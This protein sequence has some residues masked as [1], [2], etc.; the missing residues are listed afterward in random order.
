MMSSLIL[1]F[2]IGS[3]AGLF[4]GIFGIGGGSIRTPLLYLIGL[5][6][7][8]AFGINLF[9]IPFSS[10]SG[11]YSHKKNIN[12][13]IGKLMIIFGILGI[14]IGGSLAPFIPEQYLAIIF[15]ID[16]L[17][18]VSLSIGV[19]K[20]I[21][22]KEN[23]ISLCCGTLVIN[24]IMILRGGAGGSIYPIF[25]RAIGR[26]I[27]EAIATS[28][29]VSSF[30]ATVGFIMFWFHGHLPMLTGVAVAAGSTLGAKIGSKI[31]LKTKAKWL[32]LGLVGIMLLLALL[33]VFK[34]FNL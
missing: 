1:Y 10:I 24:T 2:L 31:S 22:I 3:L 20:N 12:L 5:P 18:I 4:T 27:R 6:L 34:A 19:I 29:L 26:N 17:I 33:V 16:A 28:L 23:F 30:T 25:L 15:L 13:K 8:T 21:R 7:H 11:A 32:E 9:T 14:L